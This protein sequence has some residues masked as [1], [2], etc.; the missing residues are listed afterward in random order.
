MG[1]NAGASWKG[2]DLSLIGQGV[3]DKKYYTNDW[4][5]QPFRQGSSPTREYLEGMWTE[6]NPHGAKHPKL[7]F[8]NLGGNKNTRSN[9]YFLQNASYFR[10]K[11]LTIGYTLPG[12]V[13]DKVKMSRVRV[14]FSGDNLLTFTKYYG[15]DPERTGDGRAAQYPQN[16][17]CS[18]GLNV[19]F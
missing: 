15:L 18:F 12:S 7:Y 9:S 6:E 1:T 19:E 11:N 8:D 2:F 5:M 13:T 14:Y 17:I 4:G 10:L 16:R 3:A